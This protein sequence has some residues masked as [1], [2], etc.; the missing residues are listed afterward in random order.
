MR[1]ISSLLV[2]SLILI[3]CSNQQQ[4][5][6]ATT[7]S[8][9]SLL[10]LT[11]EQQLDIY[12]NIE[13]TY[14]VNV[15]ASGKRVKELP[16]SNKQID[17]RVTLLNREFA[18]IHELMQ[19]TMMSGV[20]VLKDGEIVLEAYA[21][22]RQANDRWTSFSVAKSVTSILVGAALQDGYIK[23]LNDPVTDYIP[24]LKGS[25]YDGVN[26]R[27]LITMT[28]GV[29]WNED[30]ADVNSDV[31]QASSWVGEPGVNPLVSYM[32]RLPREAEPGTKFVYKTGET[33]MAGILLAN[34]VGKN[35]AEYLSEKIWQPYGME[36][37]AIWM[38]DRGGKERGGCCMSTTLRDYARIGQFLL[39]GGKAG[40]EQVVPNWYIN[41]ATSNQIKAPAEGDYGYFWWMQAGNSYSAEGIFGQKIQIDPEENL[42]MVINSAYPTATHQ[43]F[44]LAEGELW[45]AVR[46]ELG[47]SN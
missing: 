7:D 45:K 14:P 4:N 33:D 11:P 10:R 17:P 24:D 16:I 2:S 23:S 28:S 15:V 38:L 44:G 18:N 26:V 31:S 32:S 21:H 3:A 29:K 27:Q 22:G 6:A 20:L 12:R 36:Q 41:E 35:L 37:D 34:A 46:E 42:V 13:N 9:P 39:E 19:H 5:I 30:Y 40:G 43:I 1:I 25:A 8:P 47:L